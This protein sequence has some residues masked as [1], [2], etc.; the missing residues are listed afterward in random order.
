MK[1]LEKVKA[2][3]KQEWEERP[4]IV[5]MAGTAVA[6]TAIHVVKMMNETR[7]SHAWSKEVDR[8]DKM[9]R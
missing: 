9:T 6:N 7:N 3:L 4:I 1:K 5:I 8:R 2:K